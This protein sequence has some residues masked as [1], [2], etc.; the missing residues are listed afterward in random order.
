MAPG[1]IADGYLTASNEYDGYMYVFGIGPSAT[2]VTAPQTV[3]PKGTKVMITGTVTD[4]SP[5]QKD[6]PCISDADMTVWMEYLHMQ[7]PIPGEATGV[8]VTLYAVDQKGD[9][10]TIGTATS[11]IGG[12]YGIIWEPPTEGQYTIMATFDGTNSY[13]S[14]Y[15]TTK[16]GVGP[17]TS[18]TSP[19]EPEPT[20]AP[21]ITTEIAIIAAVAIAVVIGIVAF[22]ILRKRK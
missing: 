12:N 2:T 20:E 22:W 11:D 15:A 21:F 16:L 18:A 6:T 10:L 9:Y 17:A 19:I 1:A 7:K 13:G 3:V 14:S 8:P 5:G 4:Q